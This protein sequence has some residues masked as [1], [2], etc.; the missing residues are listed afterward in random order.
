MPVIVG[1]DGIGIYHH[2]KRSDRLTPSRTPETVAES[3][4]QQ[5]GGFAGYTRESEQ[6]TGDDAAAGCGQNHGG[7]GPP[8]AGA[9]GHGALAEAA[10][11]GAKKLFGAAHGDGNH[12]DAESQ[13]TGN[14][15]EMLDGQH[16]Q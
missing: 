4:E 11:Y 12:H 10:G 5:R 7:D 1:G 9:Q 6:H 15:R 14:S 16:S 13:A 3:S 8:F 2:R